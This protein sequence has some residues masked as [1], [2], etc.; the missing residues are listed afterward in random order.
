MSTKDWIEKD[1]YKVLG[2]S[3][4]ASADE[5]KKAFRKIAR[6]N[7][8]DQNPDNAAAEKR[9]KEA[10]EANSILSDAKKRKEYDDARKLFGGGGFRFPGSGGGSGRG[11]APTAEDLFRQAQ[12]GAGDFG[13]IFGGLFN[14]GSGGRTSTGGRGPRRGTDVEGEVTLDFT[15]AVAGKTVPI[16]MVSTDACSACHGTGARAG[17][18]P[19]VCP[20][21]HGSGM[22]T[23]TSGGVFAV[24]EPCVDCRGR[25][26]IVEDPCPVCNGSGRAKST[27]TMQVRIP[28][29][30][31]DGQR[32]RIKGKGGA[33]ENGGAAGD[34]YVIVHV[35]PHP[36]FG[37][38]GDNLTVSVPITFTEAALGAQIEVPTLNGLPVR[39]KVPAGTPNGRTFRARGKGITRKDGTPGDLL[40]T[41]EV[42]V[43]SELSEDARSALQAYADKA[44]E[45][46]PR[47]G[48][49]A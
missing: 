18:M 42:V 39:L 8:P 49:G 28:A 45:P 36:V 35:L 10:S 2:V 6:E 31:T 40:V 20:T 37:R 34:L 30:V 19:K 13:D 5:I 12:G 44:S 1:Y 24:S 7:H 29:G 3:K 48:L 15:D 25:G 22:T 32:I 26:L 23:S 9:F 38:S 33:G 17:T 47:A 21:C 16:Q 4:D 41:V 11:G 43:P 27:R 46:D 14:R